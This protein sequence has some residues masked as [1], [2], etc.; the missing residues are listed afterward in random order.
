METALAGE[1]GV[2][3]E[4]VQ[5]MSK[6]KDQPIKPGWKPTGESQDLSELEDLLGEATFKGASLG[7]PIPSCDVMIVTGAALEYWKQDK[8]PSYNQA[9][10]MACTVYW[11]MFDQGG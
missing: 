11:K 3:M 9:Y 2:E 5:E 1:A 8:V 10:T 7:Y 4:V 6:R